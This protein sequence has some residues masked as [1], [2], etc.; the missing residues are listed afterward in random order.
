MWETILIAVIPATAATILTWVL[1]I[2]H[3]KVKIATA[4]AE[5]NTVE[6]QNE[7]TIFESY[8]IVLKSY[9]TQLAAMTDTIKITLREAAVERRNS[10]K[11]IDK[12]EK[13]NRD[14]RDVLDVLISDISQVKGVT[15]EELFKDLPNIP[16]I[17]KGE[18]LQDLDLED[19]YE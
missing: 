16:R 1:N 7:K 9:Q 13:D 17:L 3:N 2:R 10:K 8:D 18:D 4:I 15:R 6:K 19:D 11:R 12:L 14:L 5:M